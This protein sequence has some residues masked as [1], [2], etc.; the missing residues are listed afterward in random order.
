M[1]LKKTVTKL[2]AVTTLAGASGLIASPADASVLDVTCVGQ[3]SRTYSPGLLLTDQSIDVDLDAVMSPCVSTDSGITAGTYTASYTQS[4][5]CL[6]LDA[7]ANNQ[8]RVFNW[9]DSSSSTMTAN[10]TVQR[11][12]LTT[13]VTFTGTISSGK[14]AGDTAVLV[15]TVLN[16]S[17]LNCLSSPGVTSTTGTVTLEITSL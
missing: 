9:N 2:V 6:D 10:R 4:L 13:V 8:T 15:V 16:P 3:E 1:N 7:N 12:T 5:S 17:V 11:L 14:F